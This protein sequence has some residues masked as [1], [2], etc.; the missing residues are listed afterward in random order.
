MSDD[1]R[2]CGS[3][4]CLIND[5]GFC[6]CGQRWIKDEMVPVTSEGAPTSNENSKPLSTDN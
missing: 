3:G 4:V 2:C 5:E 1:N 6:W